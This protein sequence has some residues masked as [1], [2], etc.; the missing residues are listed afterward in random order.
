MA[1]PLSHNHEL[2]IATDLHNCVIGLRI[3]GSK[4]TTRAKDK[5]KSAEHGD[6]GTK[7]RRA[8]SLSG[9]A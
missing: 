5:E 7:H 9:L 2:S 1:L 8:E 4:C 3:E 6:W